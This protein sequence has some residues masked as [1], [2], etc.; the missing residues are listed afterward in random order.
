MPN[1]KR[2]YKISVRIK[3]TIHFVTM[4]TIPKLFDIDKTTEWKKYLDGYGYV[5]IQ[6][7]LSDKAK[8]NQKIT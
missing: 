4:S 7:I 1:H 5:V 3:D 6:N 2:G 8:L